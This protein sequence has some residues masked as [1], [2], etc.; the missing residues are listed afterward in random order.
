MR[1]GVDLRRDPLNLDALPPVG[2]MGFD[3]RTELKPHARTFQFTLYLFF[4]ILPLSLALTV[5]ARLLSE[6]LASWFA[7]A[8]L[9]ATSVG[10]SLYAFFATDWRLA[11]RDP[12]R[13]L[14]LPMAIGP[15]G[16]LLAWL[17]SWTEV[18]AMAA[19]LPLALGL[20][21]TAF[22]ADR[23]ATHFI[24]WSLASPRLNAKNR[25]CWQH[26]WRHRFR[27]QLPVRPTDLARN[28]GPL[29]DRA[30]VAVQAYRRCMLVLGGGYL[31]CIPLAYLLSIGSP[32][33]KME[34]GGICLLLLVLALF[35]FA[36]QVPFCPPA[37]LR[38]A[39]VN[40]FTYNAHETRAP[41]VWVS[42]AG[43]FR[44]RVVVSTLALFLL[45]F[46]V[47]PMGMY[48][49]VVL[50]GGDAQGWTDA[51]YRTDWLRNWI[52][53]LEDASLPPPIP[54]QTL[55]QYLTPDQKSYFDRLPS[56][57][58]RNDYLDQLAYRYRVAGVDAVQA[59]SF[60]SRVLTCISR[61]PESWI[62]VAVVGSVHGQAT[63]LWS[64]LIAALLSMIMPALLFL[65]ILHCA[66][67][68]ALSAF[69]RIASSDGVDH[70]PDRAT[71]WECYVS[72]L[73]EAD[74]VHERFGREYDPRSHLWL[75]ATV[76]NNYPVFLHRAILHDHAHILGDS[77]TGKTSLA[78]A[79]LI[80][81][82][83][84][85]A[86]PDPQRGQAGHSIVILDLKGEPPL[87][88]GTRIEARAA[89]LPFKHFTNENG[90]PTHVFN[91]FLQPCFRELSPNQQAE[92]LLQALGLEHG[93]GYGHS[94]FSRVNRAILSKTLIDYSRTAEPINSF[95]ALQEVFE[96]KLLFNVRDRQRDA[97]EELIATAGSLAG[98]DAL[99]A[100]P[101]DVRMKLIPQAVLDQAIDMGDVLERPQVTYFYLPAAIETASVREI[102]KLALYSLLT[103][104]V[105]HERIHGKPARVYLVIDEFQ[106]II[107]KNLEL[108]LRQARSK[109]I[110]MILANQAITDLQTNDGD[111]APT[112]QANT[113]FRQY[114]SAGDLTQQRLLMEASGEAMF[115]L[116][117]SFEPEEP[118]ADDTAEWPRDGDG[119]L[120]R[121]GNVKISTRLSRNDVIRMSDDKTQCLI[122]VQ[123]GMGFAQF[124]GF[125]VLLRCGYHVSQATFE[126]HKALK[127]PGPAQHTITTPKFPADR[128]HIS[129]KAPPVELKDLLIRDDKDDDARPL[130]E[131]EILTHVYDRPVPPKPP[132]SKRRSAPTI[133]P[134]DEVG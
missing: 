127:W 33:G 110:A 84:R 3:Y 117:R 93:E 125:P 101:Q 77:G 122:Q 65:T 48:F 115:D 62:L 85:T 70:R 46:S 11:A 2:G 107:A 16:W 113:R 97:A 100:A 89:G 18:P 39:V 106:Q 129:D 116:D 47:A 15:A 24:S 121:P 71:E 92:I 123:H 32:L 79:P 73:A 105:R 22:L 111:L 30:V 57:G 109:G 90:R 41:G 1:I 54:R 94:Y 6:Y 12:V 87:F 14:L 103:A 102:A 95:K 45:V 126:R 44:R 119:N 86:R 81:Q 82:L 130:T 20:G 108:L 98:F 21:L 64:L 91:P 36:A 52:P 50:I 74:P 34:A 29:W 49:P 61:R 13:S 55:R 99:T 120:I 10:W 112:V 60:R 68:N 131:P 53:G 114:F 26:L 8:V 76:L 72:R 133:L 7:F 80:A 66:T 19:T 51:A 69:H 58:A 28:R 88:R 128:R 83:I 9:T 35:Y 4:V 23:L 17:A 124:Q 31:A 59:G 104:A 118:L 75:G 27:R 5:V 37:V 67:G 96:N 56:D 42:P 43:G 78:L 63:C 25:R 134:G 38:Q 40:W 132:K